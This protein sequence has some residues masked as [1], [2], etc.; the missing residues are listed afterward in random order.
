MMEFSWCFGSEHCCATSCAGGKFQRVAKCKR[1]KHISTSVSLI[2]EWVRFLLDTWLQTQKPHGFL[3][4]VYAAKRVCLKNRV[5]GAPSK[6][7]FFGSQQHTPLGHFQ[8][9]PYAT[10]FFLCIPLIPLFARN[11]EGSG[12]RHGTYHVQV[13]AVVA[14]SCIFHN[15]SLD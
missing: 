10:V 15:K 14:P 4:N 9:D 3:F 12:T 5:P 6:F 11:Y 7:R 13:N 8:T 2:L 1:P